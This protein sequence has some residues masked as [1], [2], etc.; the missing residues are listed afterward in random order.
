MV[1]W[2]LIMAGLGAATG[3]PA[4]ALIAFGAWSLGAAFLD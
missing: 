1:A 4:G 2:T 3:D